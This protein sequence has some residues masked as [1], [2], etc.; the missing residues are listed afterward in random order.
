[1]EIR[2]NL[3]RPQGRAIA[4]RA[5]HGLA[6]LLGIGG[7]ALIGCAEAE[8]DPGRADR[9]VPSVEAANVEPT[10]PRPT[11]S[12]Q[13]GSPVLSGVQSPAATPA[14][15]FD[16]VA[17]DRVWGVAENVS[18][19]RT[20]NAEPVLAVRFPAGSFSPG[21]APPHPL[22]GAGFVAK[23]SATPAERACLT[24]R[25]RFSPGFA[26]VKG[27]KLPGLYGGAGPTGGDAVTGY[28]GF[29]VRLMWRRN[30]AGEAYAYVANKESDYGASLG[31]GA[32]SFAP[33]AWTEMA[34]EA[35]M[36][37]PG[38]PDGILRV[39]ADGRLVL[40]HTGIL[41]RRRADQ[42]VDGLMF[43]TFFGGGDPSW[44]TPVDQTIR[45]ADFRLYVE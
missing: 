14:D 5:W 11:C 13:Y 9:P 3:V 43:S 33:D 25:I 19:E 28:D 27:G 30:G 8:S 26:F 35:V 23:T 24:Y 22:G 2:F 41:Y 1:M 39:W 34:L 16:A 40:E 10:R 37:S 42:G 18:V 17:I 12:E 7:L 15:W 44:A 38:V 36:N 31:R 32:W 4:H 20:P 45:F 21:R 6:R 29:S